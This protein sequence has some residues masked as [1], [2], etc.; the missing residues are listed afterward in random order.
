[1]D[2]KI[3]LK[4]VVKE[5][6]LKFDPKNKFKYLVLTKREII[7]RNFL[8]G[9]PD[10]F[11]IKYG[12]KNKNKIGINLIKYLNTKDYRKDLRKQ[13]GCVISQKELKDELKIIN[14]IPSKKLQKETENFYKKIKKNIKDTKRL[15]LIWEPSKQE[16]KSQIRKE[17]VLHEFIHELMEDN[18]IRP[19]DWRWNE[20]LITYIT[21]F[22]I[23]KLYRFK[24]KP[25]LKQSP[26]WKIYARYTRKW[27]KILDNVE[28]LRE[29]KK[30]I[31]KKVRELNKLARKRI[32]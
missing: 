30:I 6:D 26:M 17:I 14:K 4:K 31:L 16:E 7:I 1:M 15:T 19:R 25:K 12:N 21:N 28:S 5:F 8:C 11:Y 22:V 24:E 32:H 20:G 13:Q 27:I 18:R 10:P 29:R 3:L 9:C 23:G 2:V